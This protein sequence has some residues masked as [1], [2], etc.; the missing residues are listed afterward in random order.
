M[1]LFVANW[2]MFKTYNH[3]LKFATDHRDELD[4]LI[5]SSPHVIA[6]AP[7]FVCLD[8]FSRIFKGTTI[9]LC[10]QDCS[11]FKAGP[12]TGEIDARSL[13]QLGCTFAIID[14]SERRSLCP[15]TYE[16]IA[17]K[18]ASL[19]QSRITPIICIGETLE[20]FESGNTLNVLAEQLSPIVRNLSGSSNSFILA[21]EPIWSIGTGKTPSK[22][23]LAD[24]FDW[25]KNVKNLYYCNAFFIYGGS[26]NENNAG[27]I[28]SIPNVDGLL[29][30][31]ASRDFQTLK[32]I[33]SLT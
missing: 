2:K 1:A 29:I 9:N 19:I 26:I 24:V 7:S 10:A 15:Q 32:K 23:H 27:E 33:V 13:A 22:E 14:H 4:H 25:L 11:A 31:K 6:I 12:Y 8:A 28:L 21:Y 20:E 3:S 16:T 17:A 30:G 18:G 5:K